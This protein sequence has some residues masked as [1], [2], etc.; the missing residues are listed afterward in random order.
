MTEQ[1]EISIL[2]KIINEQGKEIAELKEE[3]TRLKLK[4]ERYTNLF[5]NTPAAITLATLKGKLIAANKT[6]VSM[7]GYSL[8]ELENMNM[9]DLYETPGDR[10]TLI[11]MLIKEGT[12]INTPMRLKRRDGSVYN[13]L[14][15]LSKIQQTENED[16]YQCICIDVSER[17]KIETEK[18]VLQERL[19]QSRKLDSIAVLAGGVAHQF[20][21]ALA[22]IVGNIELYE[23]AAKT[24]NEYS[25][26]I[27]PIKETAYRM[28][29]LTEQLLDY[30][31]GTEFKPKNISLIDFIKDTLPLIKHTLK[32]GITLH[33][34][35]PEQ[36]H[37][38]DGDYSKLQMV[39]SAI[40]SNSSEAI[41]ESGN[42][43][44]KCRETDLSM[45]DARKIPDIGP[46][47]YIELSISDDG[48][49]MDE[50]TRKRIFEPFFSTKFYGS[51]LG[52]SAVYGIIKKHDGIIF[53]ES[54][55]SKGTTI[56]IYFR[57]VEKK[58]D[59]PEAGRGR[60]QKETGNVLLVEDEPMVMS[61]NGAILETLGFTVLKAKTGQE[62]IDIAE[63]FSGE[64]DLSLL[65]IQLPDM[66]GKAVYSNLI[67]HRPD[68]RVIVCSGYSSDGPA[69]EIIDAGAQDFIQKPFSLKVLSE[70]IRDV[71]NN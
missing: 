56:K 1:P 2:K 13:A 69:K 41:E 63:S 5:D 65:D 46:G 25:R 28:A 45:E 27:K 16:L 15:T 11:D 35:I 29:D 48:K 7:T 54:A 67:K 66:D 70:K 19:E 64:I 68:I 34:D 17:D 23:I 39:L 61:V 40:I 32:P 21:N 22:A 38:I 43:W 31:R 55:E 24:A 52:M 26:F 62:A 4:D 12:L 49:G 57:A 51:G 47:R 3:N 36:V 30:A 14:L 53:I 8:D 44:I 58:P 37:P 59:I 18:K 50:K 42:I 9:Q 71:L 60:L 20:N 10:K 33:T 6:M